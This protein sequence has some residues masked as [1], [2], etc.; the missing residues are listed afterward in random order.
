MYV[1]LFFSVR[2]CKN[3]WRKTRIAFMRS[4]KLIKRGTPPCRPYYLADH[5]NFIIP[6]IKLREDE[7][8]ESQHNPTYNHIEIKQ[9]PDDTESDTDNDNHSAMTSNYEEDD[10][11]NRKKRKRR[12]SI[13]NNPRKMFLF[14]L[15]PDVESLTEDEM[16]KFRKDVLVSIHNIMSSRENEPND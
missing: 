13:E 4:L 9:D 1:C 12:D 16:R 7:D 15:L 8:H 14:S 10:E 11:K 3:K 2:E 6:F 5:L